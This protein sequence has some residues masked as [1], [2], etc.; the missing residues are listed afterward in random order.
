MVRRNSGRELNPED[1][2]DSNEE[3]EGSP[4]I[5]GIVGQVQGDEEEEDGI[6]GGSNIILV[7]PKGKK[8]SAEEQWDDANSEEDS[9]DETPAANKEEGPADSDIEN[10]DADW[11]A[12][13]ET[14]EV[15]DDPVRMYL[16][17]IGRVRLLTSNDERVLARK[18]EGRKHLLNL[19]KELAELEGRPASPWEV[20][21]ALLR[22]L[23]NSAPLLHALENQVGLPHDLPLS[24]IVEEPS[25]RAAIDAEVSLDMIA[26]IADALN[27]E[28][29][30]IYKKLVFLSLDSWILPTAAIGVMEDC[31]LA[32]LEKK[33]DEASGQTENALLREEVTEDDIAG[34]V[35]RWTGIPMDR[36]L[37]GERDKLLR[38]EDALHE[39]VILEL[40]Q[41]ST[42]GTVLEALEEKFFAAR[43]EDLD[44]DAHRMHVR[45]HHRILIPLDLG[46]EVDAVIVGRVDLLPR[47]MN[48]Q[49]VAV[50]VRG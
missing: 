18:L 32:E 12:E 5:L 19:G 49:A 46:L 20:T 41:I 37:E 38:M 15:L 44:I 33:L 17:E 7:P 1:F 40:I 10:D 45:L 42:H 48:S 21:R 47:H 30:E 11:E 6:A 2:L 3:E 31:T 9:S 24:Q 22:R 16:R 28:E 8:D 27:E 14:M 29:S 36:M 35:S 4:N 34:V 25:L 23:V 26:Y 43:P 50:V 13:T 39:R